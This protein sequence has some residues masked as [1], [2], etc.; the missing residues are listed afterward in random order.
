MYY[1]EY[2]EED[3]RQ[4]AEAYAKA[5]DAEVAIWEEFLQGEVH[6]KLADVITQCLEQ[7]KAERCYEADETLLDNFKYIEKDEKAL[8]IIRTFLRNQKWSRLHPA[9][10]QL[11]R[12]LDLSQAIKPVV[13]DV[14]LR[15][16]GV[17]READGTYVV[18][19]AEFVKSSKGDSYIIRIQNTSE[20]W[21]AVPSNS[22]GI[23]VFCDKPAADNWSHLKIT[24]VGFRSCKG[25]VQ[26][27]DFNDQVKS[28]AVRYHQRQGGSMSPS[29]K[30]KV[31]IE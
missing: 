3:R 17:Y 1:D 13:G 8:Q 23:I 2:T 7:I 28:R 26:Y 15:H 4:I 19:P 6:P 18:C 10:D 20:G 9:A 27:V 14:V 16:F 5:R 22:P 21:L 11:A 25:E 12:Q 24:N 29:T 30:I 31:R